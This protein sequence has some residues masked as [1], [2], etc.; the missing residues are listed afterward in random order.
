MC[1]RDSYWLFWSFLALLI[2]QLSGFYTRA[3]G[4]AG[5]YKALVVFRAVSLFMVIFVFS[6]YFLFRGALVPRGVAVIGWVLTLAAIGGT[7]LTKH[8]FLSMYRVELKPQPG[9]VEKVLV[10][11][12]AGYLGSALVPQLLARGYTAVSYTHLLNNLYGPTEAA[13]EV[14]YWACRRGDTRPFVPIGRP[15]AN[16]QIY[17]LD[18]QLQPAPLG[19]AG[20]L[21]IGGIGLARGYLNRP[22]LTAER[23]IPDPFRSEP[24]ARL[25]KLSLI[26]I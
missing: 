12:G 21:H 17:I 15:I 6:D 26:H 11:G 8:R 3:R 19:V 23:F 5:R 24:G 10:L 7:R 25:Y 2:F 4:Y 14:T 18:A 20:E 1:I 22:Q 16:I 9:R 13:V